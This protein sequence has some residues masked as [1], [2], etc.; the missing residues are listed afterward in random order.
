MDLDV[1]STP[2][3]LIG[4][5]A[6]G[7]ARLSEARLK[8]LGFGIGHLPVLIALRDGRASTQRDLARFARIEQPP[9][10]QMLARME[11]DGLVR[12]APDPADGRSHHITLTPVAEARLPDAVAALLRGNREVL[13]TFTDKEAELLIA[14]LTRLIASLD[15][16]EASP[17][18]GVEGSGQ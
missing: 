11:R 2:G 3:H 13:G 18:T 5:A 4:L 7:F 12:R 16:V 6:R 1:L 10:A 9:M 14:L 8:P 15:R 17:R